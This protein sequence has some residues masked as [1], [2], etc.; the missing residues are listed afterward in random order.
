VCKAHR[1]VC[2]STLGWRVIKKKRSSVGQPC[3]SPSDGQK[4]DGA[5]EKAGKQSTREGGL[6]VVKRP[7]IFYHFYENR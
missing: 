6:F 4:V 3:E 5:V 7:N 1:L 2:H